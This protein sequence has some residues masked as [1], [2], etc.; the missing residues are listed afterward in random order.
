MLKLQQGYSYAEGQDGRAVTSIRQA[1]EGES[2]RIHVTDGIY[3][4][5]VKERQAV[6]RE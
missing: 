1:E 5:V 3:T 2:L 6:E 4:A